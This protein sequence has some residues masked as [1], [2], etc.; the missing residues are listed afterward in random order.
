MKPFIVCCAVSGL[1]AFLCGPI[2]G[3]H[4]DRIHMKRWRSLVVGPWFG[5]GSEGGD[6]MTAAAGAPC[7][8]LELLKLLIATQG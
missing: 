1:V 3:D 6:F 5:V 7:T 8:P 4:P 2:L